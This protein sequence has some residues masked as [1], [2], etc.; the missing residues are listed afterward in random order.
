MDSNR[1]IAY[2]LPKENAATVM[3]RDSESLYHV[4]PDKGTSQAC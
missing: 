1:S 2:M 4:I 3:A